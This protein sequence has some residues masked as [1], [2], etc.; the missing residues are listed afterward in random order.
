MTRRS[1]R[2]RCCVLP[3]IVSAT[4]GS[5]AE[6]GRCHHGSQS[7]LPSLTV[8]SLSVRRPALA[9]PRRGCILLAAAQ[10]LRLRTRHTAPCYIPLNEGER[11]RNSVR[12]GISQDAPIPILALGGRAVT[13]GRAA[14]PSSDTPVGLPSDQ[15]T[16]QISSLNPHQSRSWWGFFCSSR[17][18]PRSMVPAELTPAT[19]VVR[20]SPQVSASS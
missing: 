19:P 15:R 12:A 2:H 17:V 1:P 6:P 18:Q 14:E 20:M 10:P 11:E 8:C 4:T 7:S 5:A 16:H 9:P 13:A 3:V